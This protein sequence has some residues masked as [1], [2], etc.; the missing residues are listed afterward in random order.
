M[1]IRTISMEDAARLLDSCTNLR[2][3]LLLSLLFETGM[4]IGEA[5][6]LWLEDFDMA[7]L[8]ITLHDRGEMENL[9]EIKTVSSPRRLDCTQELMDLFTGYICETPCR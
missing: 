7:G 9:A 6:S 5:L 1:Q 4:R 3:Y 8:T 2:D